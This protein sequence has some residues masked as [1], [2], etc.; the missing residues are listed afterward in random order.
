VNRPKTTFV[1]IKAK[2]RAEEQGNKGLGEGMSSAI[3]RE[4]KTFPYT[5]SLL[6]Y[7]SGHVQA[8]VRTEGGTDQERRKTRKGHHVS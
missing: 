5:A 1:P 8:E 2:Q 4:K 3:N 7:Q 6:G